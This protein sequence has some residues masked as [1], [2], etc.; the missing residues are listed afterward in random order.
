VIQI[1]GQRER[2]NQILGQRERRKSKVRLSSFI[3]AAR[4]SVD[5]VT[6][7]GTLAKTFVSMVSPHADTFFLTFS[8]TQCPNGTYGTYGNYLILT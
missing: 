8:K 1:L 7:F 6:T 2:R 4:R 5:F 3:V